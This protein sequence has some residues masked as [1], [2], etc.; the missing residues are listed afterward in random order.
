[1]SETEEDEC[2]APPETLGTGRLRVLV[3]Q[4]ESWQW[5]RRGK[6]GAGLQDHRFGGCR[7]EKHAA[8]NDAA[9]PGGKK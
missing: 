8:Q 5:S 9:K 7:R 1:M 6:P 4:C 2:P 3:D